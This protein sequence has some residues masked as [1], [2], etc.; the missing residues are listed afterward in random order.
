MPRRK[1]TQGTARHSWNRYEG[2]GRLMEVRW[3]IDRSQSQ[4]C[5]SELTISETRPSA[6]NSALGNKEI[7]APR[8][9]D[10][11][12][13]STA[14]SRGSGW[15]RVERQRGS[16]HGFFWGS[17]GFIII[18]KNGRK[19]VWGWELGRARSHAKTEPVRCRRKWKTA[20]IWKP[21]RMPVTAT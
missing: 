15:R 8:R 5:E 12:R 11:G 16:V 21:L 10:G 13:A 17:R 9:N 20:A 4:T 6:P 1:E 19:C 3:I 7:Q 14:D 18:P 2:D